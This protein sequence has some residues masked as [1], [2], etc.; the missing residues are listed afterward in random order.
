MANRDGRYSYSVSDYASVDDFIAALSAKLADS[1]YAKGSIVYA[2]GKGDKVTLSYKYEIYYNGMRNLTP[3]PYDTVFTNT[4]YELPNVTYT[5][6]SGVGLTTLPE[7]NEQ[8]VNRALWELTGDMAKKATIIRENG[9]YKVYFSAPGIYTLTNYVYTEFDTEGNKTFDKY[10]RSTYYTGNS[11]VSEKITVEVKDKAGK[12]KITFRTSAEHPF[13]E[14]YGGGTEYTAEYDLS[15]DGKVP[16]LP[17]QAFAASGST[18]MGW[19]TKPYFTPR[20]SGMLNPGFVVNNFTSTFNSDDV[21]L[22]ACWDDKITITL[23]LNIDAAD[24]PE[25]GV[26]KTVSME[27]TNR[28]SGLNRIGFY[29]VDLSALFGDVVSKYASSV[30]EFKNFVNA[31]GEKKVTFYTVEGLDDDE[32]LF[33]AVYAKQY[34]VKFNIDARDENGDK[35]SGTFLGNDSVYTGE[36]IKPPTKEIVCKKAG[37]EFKYWS[38]S[39]GG[40]EYDFSTVITDEMAQNGAITLYAVFGEIEDD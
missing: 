36:T 4:Y 20:H 30:N 12:V 18:L 39:A 34:K 10:V 16:L 40:E 26:K 8:T 28:T 19:V 17:A 25:E 3:L 21:D 35:Y 14:E 32:Y 15:V 29:Y 11:V 22:Y 2:S 5:T 31:K 24:F 13:T 33:T 23:K 1:E 38:L 9:K 37:Y 6:K 7:D 27:R